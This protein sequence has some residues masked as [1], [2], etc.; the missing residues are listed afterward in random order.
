MIKKQETSPNEDADA[1][2]GRRHSSAGM[3][4]CEPLTILRQAGVSAVSVVKAAP[5]C[6]VVVWARQN[7]GSRTSWIGL[8][9]LRWGCLIIVWARQNRGSRSSWRSV[10]ALLIGLGYGSPNAAPLAYQCWLPHGQSTGQVDGETE[11]QKIADA[12]LNDPPHR[13]GKRSKPGAFL[14]YS[15]FLPFAMFDITKSSDGCG[16]TALARF[17]GGWAHRSYLASQLGQ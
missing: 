9:R 6:L 11:G 4:V 2:R 1:P 17:V 8:C 16:L 10:V 15:R 14:I 12:L 3:N 7:R 5:G 13:K